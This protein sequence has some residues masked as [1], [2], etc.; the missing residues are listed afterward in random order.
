MHSS[1]PYVMCK[2]I[3]DKVKVA[4]SNENV[5]NNNTLN[6]IPTTW[7]KNVLH[8]GKLFRKQRRGVTTL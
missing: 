4:K 2:R 3:Y 7:S 5:V 1:G 8:V 6:K